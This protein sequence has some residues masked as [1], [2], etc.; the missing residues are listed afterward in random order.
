LRRIENKQLEDELRVNEKGERDRRNIADIAR[1]EGIKTFG[2]T[3]EEI[4]KEILQKRKDEALKKAGAKFD[5]LG[6][7]IDEKGAA[8]ARKPEEMLLDVVKAIK[9]LVEKIEPKLP[10]HALAL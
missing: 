6:Q 10:T 7:P 8:P 4:R 2:K 1:K 5:A 9:A 3:N